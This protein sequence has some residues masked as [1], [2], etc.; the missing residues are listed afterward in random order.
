M[1]RFILDIASHNDSGQMTE[2]EAQ[3]I[4]ESVC[5]SLYDKTSGI[6]TIVPID[7]SNENQF[8]SEFDNGETNEL[9]KEQIE[10]FK[11]ICNNY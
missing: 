7:L 9:S 1:A 10:N 8:Y 5:E 3:K 11:K 4:C 6:I 2:L